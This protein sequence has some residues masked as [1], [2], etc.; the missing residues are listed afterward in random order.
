MAASG[1]TAHSRVN[2]AAPAWNRDRKK[3]MHA[4][5]A[6]AA[7]LDNAPTRQT[8]HLNSVPLSWPHASRSTLHERRGEWMERERRGEQQGRGGE[9]GG[10]ADS[11]PTRIP[12]RSATT[13]SSRA[14]RGVALC[15]HRASLRAYERVTPVGRSPELSARAGGRRQ[16]AV[17]AVTVAAARRTAGA[18]GTPPLASMG[19]DDALGAPP[20]R[21]TP[22]GRS[23][24]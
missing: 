12:G 7:P 16:Q 1:L 10:L 15:C 4:C 22:V 20:K 5:C 19:D 3:T 24:E 6:A 17:H 18:G 14:C 23:P 21:V 13:R 11:M 8:A 2:R 9:G